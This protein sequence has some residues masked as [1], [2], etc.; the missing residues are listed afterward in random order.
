VCT[1]RGRDIVPNGVAGPE[2]DP[3]GDRAVLLLRLGELLLR[4]ERLV[5]L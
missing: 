5:A 3:L 2:T 1:G 4:A